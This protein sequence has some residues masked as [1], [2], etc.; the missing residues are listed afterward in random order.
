MYIVQ[1]TITTFLDLLFLFSPVSSASAV[2][3][4]PASQ[5]PATLPVNQLSSS[6]LSSNQLSSNQLSSNQQSSNTS[7]SNPTNA[8]PVPSTALSS[9]HNSYGDSGVLQPSDNIHNGVQ[10]Q[11]SDVPRRM[12]INGSH[13]LVTLQSIPSTH[14]QSSPVHQQQQINAEDILKVS[15]ISRDMTNQKQKNSFS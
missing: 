2:Y 9:V 6:Q 12:V 13:N 1:F 14:I 7:C 10:V 3:E 4:V 8:T 11:S 15:Y 5:L